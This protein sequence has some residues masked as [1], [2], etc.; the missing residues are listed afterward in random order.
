MG[1]LKLPFELIS[2]IDGFEPISLPIK[3]DNSNLFTNAKG[4]VCGF[5]STKDAI[6]NKLNFAKAIVIENEACTPYHNMAPSN[7]C[8]KGEDYD[9]ERACYSDLGSPLAIYI[10]YVPTL[11]GIFS[12]H[13][14]ECNQQFS[15]FYERITSHMQWLTDN[16]EARQF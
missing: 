12:T 9:R 14:W 10:D 1:L 5:G 7:L 13:S 6:S 2:K 4:K 11:I 15:V 3:S 8:T 16:S